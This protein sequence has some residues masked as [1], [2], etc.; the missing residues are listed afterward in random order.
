[1]GYFSVISSTFT[2]VVT[3]QICR[4]SIPAWT[5]AEQSFTLWADLLLSISSTL[6]KKPKIYN[7]DY[8]NLRYLVRAR[9]NGFFLNGWL[10]HT[11]CNTLWLITLL[12]WLANGKVILL[13]KC[14]FWNPICF[15]N[16]LLIFSWKNEL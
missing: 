8:G 10:Y 5:I 7:F 1:M 15:C 16:L 14:F 13:I 2:K 9:V 6:K 12:A 11:N 3:G 4:K